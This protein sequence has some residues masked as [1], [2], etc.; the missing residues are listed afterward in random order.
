MDETAEHQMGVSEARKNMTEVVQEVRI[1]RRTV[2]LTR[3]SKPQVAIV[4]MDFYERAVEALR[5]QC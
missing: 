1:L 5:I 2:I 4:P 3:R